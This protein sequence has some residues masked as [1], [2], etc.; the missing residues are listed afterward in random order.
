MRNTKLLK[1]IYIYFLKCSATRCCSPKNPANWELS[2]VLRVV[3]R[4]LR[5][6]FLV[7]RF[8]LAFAL[9]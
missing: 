6:D 8:C 4:V 7:T 3:L 1:N 9:A 2:V 5:V